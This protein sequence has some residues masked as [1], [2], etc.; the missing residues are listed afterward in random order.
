MASNCPDP[1]SQKAEDPRDH[2][3][4]RP[5]AHGCSPHAR[6]GDSLES[7]IRRKEEKRTK[8]PSKGLSRR[9]GLTSR[10]GLSPVSKK[11]KKKNA[12]YQK[13]KTEFLS[14]E[15]NQQC[16]L[17]GST[18]SLSIHHRRKRGEYVD[19]PL[20]FMTLCMMGDFMDQKYPDSNHSHAGGCHGWVEGN[21]DM[22]RQLKLIVD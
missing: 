8:A 22:A 21:K 2:D 3:S 14:D 11:Q 20:Y 19:D 16:F 13:E 12:S 1:E 10:K 18:S 4:L 6:V 15:K 17:C 5:S 9:V 7:Y